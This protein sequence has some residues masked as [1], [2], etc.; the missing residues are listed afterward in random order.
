M[1]LIGIVGNSGSSVNQFLLMHAA[2]NIPS[3]IIDC[4]NAADPHRLYP[5]VPLERMSRIYV[6]EVELLYK[7][8]DILVKTPFFMRRFSAKCLVVTTAE[9]LFH[10]QDEVENNQV[11]EHSWELM[12][13]V[14]REHTV[15]VGLKHGSTHFSFA[16]KFCTRIKE[17]RDGA[18]CRKP[19]HHGRFGYQ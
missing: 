12:K 1:V 11:I 16:Q 4:A 7:F 15:V 19:A 2:K 10:Y 13:E 9:H 6:L 8:R 5:S 3:L 17:V 18:Y 14:A